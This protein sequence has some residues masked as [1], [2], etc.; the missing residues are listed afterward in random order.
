MIDAGSVPSV[1]SGLTLSG[2]PP[3]DLQ[4]D[5]TAGHCQGLKKGL[6]FPNSCFFTYSL[7]KYSM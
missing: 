3:G 6:L 7:K 5:A 2:V 4:E 1:G